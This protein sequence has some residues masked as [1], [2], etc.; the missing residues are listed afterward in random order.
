M[1]LCMNCGREPV[2]GRDLFATPDILLPS[3]ALASSELAITL[4]DPIHVPDPMPIPTLEEFIAP[5]P[6][7]HPMPPPVYRAAPR[8]PKNMDPLLRPA[9]RWIIGLLGLGILVFLG[10]AAAGSIASLNLGSSVCL[11]SLWLLVALAWLGIVLARRGEA[12]SQ[13]TGAYRRLVTSLG[14]RLFEITP[15]AARDQRAQLPS[16]PLPTALQPASQLMYLSSAGGRAD[17]VSQ[18]LLG[19]LCALVAGGQIELARQTYDVLT[20]S[21]FSQNLKTVQRIAVSRRAL[22][23]GAGYLESL[24]AKQLIQSHTLGVRELAAAILRHA[25]ADLLDRIA[26]QAAADSPTGAEQAPDPDTQIAGLRE[27]CEEF[28]ALNPE[29]HAQL[30]QEVEEV[31]HSHLRVAG[32]R[33]R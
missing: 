7:P 2:S 13:T 25:G 17:Q 21:P 28:R 4:P 16:K 33:A 11:G 9:P 5:P 24:I 18:V 31:V 27:Y 14:Q 3:A 20:A 29:V 22:Y 10:L 15:G 8:R 32:R 12:H 26:A 6:Q 1:L 19:T 30:A 23:V